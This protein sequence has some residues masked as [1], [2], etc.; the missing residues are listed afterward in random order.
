MNFASKV[1]PKNVF[2]VL[3]QKCDMTLNLPRLL[4]WGFLECLLVLVVLTATNLLLL[5]LE[6]LSDI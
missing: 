3:S 1:D 5:L 6:P 4:A 2:Y